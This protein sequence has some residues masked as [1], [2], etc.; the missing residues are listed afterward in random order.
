MC[1]RRVGHPPLQVGVDFAGDCICVS[2]RE[3]R[4]AFTV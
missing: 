4:I 1:D 3:E 2:K